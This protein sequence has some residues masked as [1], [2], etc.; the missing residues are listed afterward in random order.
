MLVWTDANGN[1][2][3]SYLNGN[4]DNRNLNVNKFNGNW[5]DNWWFFGLCQFLY[6]PLNKFGGVSF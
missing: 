2:N 1:R 5:N 3:F 6:S 4:A